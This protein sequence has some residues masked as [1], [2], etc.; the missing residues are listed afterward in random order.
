[1]IRQKR[2]DR[3]SEA[4]L[5][6]VFRLLP[7]RDHHRMASTNKYFRNISSKRIASPTFIAVNDLQGSEGGSPDWR[8]KSLDGMYPPWANSPVVSQLDSL[9][10]MGRLTS[11]PKT[12]TLRSLM[13]T[14]EQGVG[15]RIGPFIK[16][17]PQLQKL[18]LLGI[19]QITGLGSTSV[20][21]LTI[22]TYNP[23]ISHWFPN[24]RSLT[25]T[26][27]SPHC[28]D[29]DSIGLNHPLLED[30]TF[31]CAVS[32][33]SQEL[34]A[35]PSWNNLRR[36][37]LSTIYRLDGSLCAQRL[38]KNVKKM[39]TITFLHEHIIHATELEELTL[40]L[41]GDRFVLEMV[42]AMSLL[43]KLRLLRL[44]GSDTDVD[45]FLLLLAPYRTLVIVA[46]GASVVGKLAV[47][48]H[49]KHRRS[50]ITWISS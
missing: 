37:K 30:L 38:F 5:G 24:L 22:A 1:M 32:H 21:A 33:V 18:V 29:L 48:T 20:T 14:V 31:F 43:P 26:S 34:D 25:M 12:T 3:L 4:C 28:V 19:S 16:R 23:N 49:P 47:T 44:F 13:V 39:V 50:E 40:D 2:M 10:V 42:R 17:Q 7:Y 9:T 15:H 41:Q 45:S 27:P 35:V 36:L 11:L 8:I 46:E 6:W